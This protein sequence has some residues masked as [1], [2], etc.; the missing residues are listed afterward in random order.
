MFVEIIKAF[1]TVHHDLLYEILSKYGLPPLLVQTVKKLYK[2]CKV[3]IKIGKNFTE[4]DYTTGVHQG[5]NMSPILFLFV[6]QAFL[7]IL[8]LSSK[9]I[10]F[11]HLPENKNGK[12][13][14][15]K[16]SL[17]S[18]N[19]SAKGTPFQFSSSFYVDDSF[20]VFETIQELQTAITELNQHFSH[21]GLI[22]HLGRLFIH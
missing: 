22:M 15:T 5:D 16:G 14:S 7:D 6:I 2:N 21:F 19:T 11:S 4:I 9:P 20:F 8:K 18:Q 13:N 10:N 17:L 3:K 1:D 12:L